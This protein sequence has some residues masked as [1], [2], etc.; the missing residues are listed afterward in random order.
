MRRRGRITRVAARSGA[1]CPGA[2][3]RAPAA[4][5]R[6]TRAWREVAARAMGSTATRRSRRDAAN[7]PV[8]P[9]RG[10]VAPATTHALDPARTARARAVAR[11]GVRVPISGGPSTLVRGLERAPARFVAPPPPLW[12]FTHE[13]GGG[14]PTRKSVAAARADSAR[15]GAETAIARSS[16]VG[17]RERSSRR[18]HCAARGEGLPGASLRAEDED[19]ARSATRLG[20]GGLVF[21]ERERK[22]ALL[23][24]GLVNPRKTAHEHGRGASRRG[25]I[26]AWRG[27][28]PRR[29]SSPIATSAAS[30][31]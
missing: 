6:G 9:R 4:G 24:V 29:S 26:A 7:R 13:R 15:A 20:G 14:S 21:L 16:G 19:Q 18:Q 2:A 1:P 8:T 23:S 3:P 5:S 17:H 30:A 22:H 27:S 12:G 31:V 25:D 11:A 10:A 28:S